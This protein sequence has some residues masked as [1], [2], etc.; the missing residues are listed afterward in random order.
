MGPV[1]EEARRAP[2]LTFLAGLPVARA[3]AEWAAWRH[4]GQRR[5]ADGAAFVAH[6]LEVAALLARSGYPDHVVAAAVLHDV[7]EDTDARREELEA[8]FGGEVARLV[9][10]VSDDPAV[11]DEEARKRL[12]RER[13]R[14]LGGSAAAIYAADKVS[15]VREL[16]T[17]LA[18][19][20][21]PQDVEPKLAR[22]RRSLAMLEQTMPGSRLVEL[23]RFELEELQ[24][25]PPDRAARS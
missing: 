12:V 22:H 14:R 1:S 5:A 18:R 13:V 21:R 24:Q 17:M 6:P 20:A 11:A 25:L 23:L 15:K 3:A 4:C 7:L 10:A 16:R 8:R 19:G 9:A 2:D